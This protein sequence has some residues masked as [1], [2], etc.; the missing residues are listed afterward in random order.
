MHSNGLLMIE[1]TDTEM[2]YVASKNPVL[3]QLV[4]HYAHL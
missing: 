4:N 2:F 3:K 1:Y